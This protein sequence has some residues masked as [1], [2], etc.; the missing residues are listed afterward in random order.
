MK[1]PQFTGKGHCHG[2]NLVHRGESDDHALVQIFTE[3][4]GTWSQQ[5]SFSN[6][7]LDDLI[8]VLQAAQTKIKRS[9]VKD[10]RWGMRL[11]SKD[12][13]DNVERIYGE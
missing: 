1:Q 7:W 2:V 4:D 10:G 5:M 9:G 11:R 8:L 6:Y 13:V 12:V 3:D